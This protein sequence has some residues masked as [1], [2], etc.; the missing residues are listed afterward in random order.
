MARTRY[1]AEELICHIRTVE[2]ET[3]K[4]LGIADTCRKFGITEQTYDQWKKE[5][6]GCQ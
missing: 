1:T 4:G 2:I 5:H 6:G 3:G